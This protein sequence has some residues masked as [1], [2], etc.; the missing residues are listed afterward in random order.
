MGGKPIEA[1]F[2]IDLI[3]RVY[4][5]QRVDLHRKLVLRDRLSRPDLGHFD[6]ALPNSPGRQDGSTRI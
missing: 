3:K 5:V 2:G 6:K 1:T 4:Q